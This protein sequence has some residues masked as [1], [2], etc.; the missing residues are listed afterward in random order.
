MKLNDRWLGSEGCDGL[1]KA[2]GIILTGGRGRRLN[3]RDKAL[4]NYKNMPFLFHVLEALRGFEEIIIV[5][6]ERNYESHLNSI[7]AWKRDHSSYIKGRQNI[8]VVKDI[9]PESG[10]VGGIYT[11][12][13]TAMYDRV[14]ILSVDT[15]MVTQS[16][17]RYL[18][19]VD[20]GNGKSV[21]LPCADGK[22]HPLIGV[23]SKSLHG[24]FKKALDSRQLKLMRVIENFHLDLIR[25]EDLMEKGFSTKI[26]ANINTQNDLDRI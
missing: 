17:V 5:T 11:G 2:T 25:Q 16:L 18:I 10:P 20:S 13:F 24:D 6:S 1:I 23:Y 14:C 7:E 8:E 4:I 19:D 22:V 3:D 12:L 15:P 26:F 21:T 9:I